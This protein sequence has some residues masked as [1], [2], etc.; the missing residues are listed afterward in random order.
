MSAR[1]FVL[2]WLIAAPALATSAVQMDA[3]ALTHAAT[4]II[5]GRVVSSRSAWTDDHRRLVT[6]VDVDVLENWKGH[7]GDKL[8]LVQPGGERD[9][10]GQSVAGVAPLG[11]GEELVLFLE[12]QGPLFR[13]VG[14][15]Q[16][17]YR[18]ESAP[19]GGA[20]RA[21]PVVVEGLHLVPPA[22]RMP[23]ARRALPLEE[24]RGL[25]G[26]EVQRE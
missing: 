9:G 19:S 3:P 22:G 18:V 10:F 5:R 2:V 6:F 7:A 12:R 14:L 4:D 23:G 1:S 25:V 20:A 24:L 21:V 8:T 11:V 16:G 26:R 17:V 13:V 15:S